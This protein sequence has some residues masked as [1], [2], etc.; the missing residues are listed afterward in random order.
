MDYVFAPIGEPWIGSGRIAQLGVD[1]GQHA[2][3]P[4]GRQLVMDKIQCPHLV[5]LRGIGTL[6]PEFG[7]YPTLGCLVEQLQA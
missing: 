2:H 4:A 5:A 1:D 3:L 7:F 6:L